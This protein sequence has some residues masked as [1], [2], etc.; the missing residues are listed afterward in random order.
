M[1]LL[2]S[3]FGTINGWQPFE[4]M[5]LYAYVLASYT[6]ANVFIGGVMWSLSDRIRIGDFDQTLTKPMRPLVYEIVSSFSEYYFLHFI[7]AVGMISFGVSQLGVTITF[8]NIVII[9]FGVIGGAFI[10]GGILVL[11]SAASFGMINNPLTGNFYTNIRLLA[12]FPV[13]IYPKIMQFV[14]STFVPLAFVSFFPV[15][16]LTGKEDFGI[17]PQGVQYMTLPVGIVFFSAACIIWSF[18]M[19]R[20]KST[21]S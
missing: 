1:V 21:G 15:Q 9:A 12:E 4:V 11:F 14:L 6:L 5:L 7:L 2:V 10:Q 19:R 16:Q 8:V 20:Y 13:S 17:F 18:A 3:T